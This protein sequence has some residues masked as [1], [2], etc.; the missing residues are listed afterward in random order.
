MLEAHRQKHG[1]GH[2]GDEAEDR[3]EQIERVEA[4]EPRN[5][6][7]AEAER[8]GEALLI[9]EGDDEAGEAEEEVDGEIDR[10]A[11]VVEERGRR[12]PQHDHERS[13][14][15]Q[16]VQQMEAVV[17]GGRVVEDSHAVRGVRL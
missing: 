6:K 15:T 3:A 1:P 17:C 16:R 9:G 10:V 13:D 4:D 5:Q 2:L 8:G 7:L 14:A 12:V 11:I